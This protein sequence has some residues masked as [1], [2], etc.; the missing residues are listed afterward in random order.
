[1]VITLTPLC[2]FLLQK[3]HTVQPVDVDWDLNTLEV[4][5]ELASD[6]VLLLDTSDGVSED[7]DLLMCM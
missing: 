7:A 6:C 4:S 3:R 1:M 5:V 2:V